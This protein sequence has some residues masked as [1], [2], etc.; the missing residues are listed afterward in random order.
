M[1]ISVSLFIL[2]VIECARIVQCYPNGAPSSTCGSMMPSHETNSMSCQS[3]YVIEATKYQY[4]SDDSIQITVRGTTSSDRFKGILLVAKGQSSQNILG[5]WSSIDSSVYVV[6]CDGTSSNGI[7]QASSTT[8]SQIQATWTSPSTTAQENIVISYQQ[9]CEVPMARHRLGN[10]HVFVC[11]RLNDDTIQLQ[12]FINPGGYSSP[13]IVT[14][15]SNYGGTLTVTRVALNNGVAY[16]EFTLSNFTTTMGRRRK[17]SISLLS[18]STQYRILVATGHLAGSN[19]LVQHS[20]IAVLT[21]KIQLD[22]SGTIATTNIEGSD[23]DKAMFLRAHGI[24]MLFIWILFVPTG[25]LIARYFKQSWPTRKLC[26]KQMWFAVHRSVMIFAAIMTLI[27][28]AAILK[29][30]QGTWVSQNES[31]EFA[32]SIIGMLVISAAIIQPMMALFRCHPDHQYRFIFNYVHAIVGIGALILSI[33]AI[34]LATL[35]S[36]SDTSINKPWRIVVAWESTEF[37]ILIGFECLEI[38]YRKKWSPFCVKNR[39]KPVQMNVLHNGSDAT[40]VDDRSSPENILKERLKT[41]LL[42]IHILVAFGLSLTLAYC[43]WQAS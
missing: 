10:D 38:F 35:F 18:Q 6:F 25:I 39:D 33:I 36:L 43:T 15:D 12:R 30:N 16:C 8:K 4:N 13:T 26:G 42:A 9:S 19:A 41:F 1:K 32:H 24:I 14:T 28:F 3:N 5:S 27:A 11:Q 2:L 29:Y 7:T 23:D 21:Q 40:P 22:Q 37:A 34:F 20:S 17:R 31:R